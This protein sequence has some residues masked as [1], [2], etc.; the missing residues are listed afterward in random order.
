MIS[1]VYTPQPFSLIVPRKWSM[2]VG[3]AVR[4]NHNN[5]PCRAFFECRS[6]VSQFPDGFSCGSH[7]HRASRRFGSFRLSKRTMKIYRRTQFTNFSPPVYGSLDKLFTN[8]ACDID[9]MLPHPLEVEATGLMQT[10]HLSTPSR[11]HSRFE[12]AANALLLNVIP[13]E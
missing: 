8:V 5:L 9:G 13:F 6:K 1:T 3:K 4:K 12:S 2:A 7:S 11:R 10:D